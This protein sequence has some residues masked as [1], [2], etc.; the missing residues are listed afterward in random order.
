MAAKNTGKEVN[1]AELCAT[2]GVTPPTVDGWLRNGCPIKQRGSRGVSAVFNTADVSKWLN[3]RSRDEGAGNILADEAELRRRKLAA[4]T[5]KAE[6]EYSQAKGLVAP[7]AEFERV[8]SRLM[9]AIRTN[10]MNVPS[11]AVLQLLGETSETVFKEKLRAELALALEQ[12]SD[13]DL[14]DEDDD[15]AA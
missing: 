9:A 6:L 12:S 5:G 2:F 13:A 11:R 7:I 4:E 3:D 8:Q 15:L 1:K 10:I 14:I